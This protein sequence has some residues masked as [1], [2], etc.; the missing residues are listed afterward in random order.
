MLTDPDGARV[1]PEFKKEKRF[2][3]GLIQALINKVPNGD[4]EKL[5]NIVKYI[6]RYGQFEVLTW[7]LKRIHDKFPEFANIELPYKDEPG[8]EFR[9]EAAEIIRQ[10]KKEQ[11]L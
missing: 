5:L 8:W 6:S 11:G 7:L 3:F 2:I 1:I 4:P 10:G 9:R